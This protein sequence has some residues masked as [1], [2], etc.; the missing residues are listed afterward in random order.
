MRYLN[1]YIDFIF[2]SYS[3]GKL[4]VIYSEEFKSI[5]KEIDN[6][7]SIDWSP[8]ANKLL[9]LENKWG[10]NLNKLSDYTLIDIT[11]TNSMLSFIQSNRVLNSESQKNYLDEIKRVYSKDYDAYKSTISP[12]IKNNKEHDLWNKSRNQISVGK[13]VR[14]MFKD[15]IK[16]SISDKELEKFVNQYKMYYELVKGIELELVEGE[17]IRKFYNINNYESNKGQLGNSCMASSSK[18]NFF[19]IYVKNPDVCKLLI[20]RSFRDK[21]KIKGRSL[22]WKLKDGTYYQDRIYT[23]NDHDIKTFE[24]WAKDKDMKIYNDNYYDIEVQLGNHE[25]DYYPYM[26]TFVCYNPSK[27][28]L[29]SDEDLWPGKGFIKLQRTQGGYE[30]ENVVYSEHYDEYIDRYNATHCRFSDHGH[31]FDWV[32][33]SEAV[34]VESKDEYWFIE[35]EY[36]SYSNFQDEYLHNDESVFSEIMSDCISKDSS[37][38]IKISD[39]GFDF[40]HKEEI[41]LYAF[42][43]N[44]QFYCKKNFIKDPITNDLKYLDRESS[45]ELSKL[46]ESEIDSVDKARNIIIDSYIKKN[47]NEEVIRKELKKYKSYFIFKEEEITIIIRLIYI[48]MHSGIFSSS[49]SNIE[50][51]LNIL[52]N[53]FKVKIDVKETYIKFIRHSI[54]RTIVPYFDYSI[55]GTDVYK[56]YLYLN[57]L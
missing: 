18:S 4:E 32:Y 27:K 38:E 24:K 30:S 41:N 51:V 37:I 17:D 9:D 7:D 45:K 34:Y 8:I 50:S 48:H 23:N 29:S 12:D 10:V 54:L 43:K 40:I 3:S 46:I 19:D 15:V 20:L 57:V 52:E 11:D 39:K 28:L 14:K 26:D 35:S 1:S 44:G 13:F 56:S 2:E 22:I 53:D 47:Y 5:L 25:Y 33:K 49:T 42:E 16:E 55:F 31:D 21:E 6:N 36:I